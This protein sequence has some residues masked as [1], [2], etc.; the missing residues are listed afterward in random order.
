VTTDV[1]V[2]GGGCAGLAAATDLTERGARVTVLEAR[3]VSG[4]RARSWIDPKTGDVEDNGQHLILG[5]YRE[6]LTFARRIGALGELEFHDRLEVVLLEPGGRE[7]VFRAARLPRPLDLLWGL[8]R[9]PGFPI[10]D[11]LRAGGLTRDI[12]RGAPLER[13]TVTDWLR[14]RGQSPIA[15]ERFW[16]PLVLA[17]LNLE[18]ETA[19]AGLLASVLQRA[20]LGGRDASRPGFP[21]AGLGRLLVDPAVDFIRA[22]GG[23][24][25]NRSVV[26]KIELD[27][28]GRFSGVTTRS[29]ERFAAGAAILAVPPAPAAKLLPA[30]AVDFGTK[31]AAAL[32]G[33]A[34]VAVHLWFDRGVSDYPMV[35]LLGSPFHWVFDRAR[36]GSAKPPGYLALVTSAAADL[37]E[38]GR[39]ELVRRAVEEVRRYLPRSRAA[40]LQRSRVLKERQ[41][42][43]VLS[44]D[45][46]RLRPGP[47]TRCPGL[48]LAGDWTDTGLPATLEGAAGSGHLAAGLVET[49]G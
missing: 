8:V 41:A 20:L 49:S 2:I 25:R 34:I 1:L 45:S 12:R 14:Q 28:G 22:R 24:V 30:G 7:V 38:S 13:L 26:A 35:G 4:G 32:G 17:T 3:A 43:P 33:S 11:A 18:P 10:V 40:S 23:E 29:G 47:R 39:D 27:A 6:F 5:C 36:H 31:A 16:D 15:M 46:V 48:L 37:A 9:L 21:R 44:P 42:T 19:S